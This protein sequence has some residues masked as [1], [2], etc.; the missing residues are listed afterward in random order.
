MTTGEVEVLRRRWRGRLHAAYPVLFAITCWTG[1]LMS[2][3]APMALGVVALVLALIARSRLLLLAAGVVAVAIFASN[4]NAGLRPL[5]SGPFAGHVTIISDPQSFP[6]RITVD[7][8][9]DEGRF[10]LQASGGL[11]SRIREL[12]VGAVL[13]VE[14]TLRP[15]ARPERVR[16]RHL[17]MALTVE[18]VTS[19]QSPALWRVP[20]DELRGI[21]ARGGDALPPEQQPLYRGFVIGDDRDADPEVSRAFEDAGLAHLLVVSGQ[22]VVFVLAVSAPLARRFGRRGELVALIGIIVLFAA[23]TRFEPSILRASVMAIIAVLSRSSGHPIRPLH[24]LSL[25]VAILVLIDPLLVWSFGFRLSVAATAGISLLAPRVESALR[26]PRWFRTVLSVTIAAQIGVAPFVIPTFGPMPLVSLPA[27]VL[28]EPAAGF[29]MM[30][31]S[32]VGLIAGLFGGWPATVLQF[33]ARI[34]L[35]WITEVAR[36]CS[37]LSLP[38]LGVPALV[39]GAV[40]IGVVGAIRRPTNRAPHSHRRGSVA[41]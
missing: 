25:A 26:G 7:V 33:P 35:W 10:E 9:S 24:R 1:A 3:S 41:G 36:H 28:A 39:A 2:L 22:N 30:W 8:A 18:H 14:G 27:N 38:G 5:A 32:S 20:V 4:A 21:V 11:A 34:G 29:V 19:V 40:V 37:D 13:A 23:V 6:G 31:G 15:L 12:S 16:S 17:R